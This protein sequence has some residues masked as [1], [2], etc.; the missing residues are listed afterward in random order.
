MLY[1][2]NHFAGHQEKLTGKETLQIVEE[3]AYIRQ[4]TKANSAYEK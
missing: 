2:N 3:K 1:I 4:T